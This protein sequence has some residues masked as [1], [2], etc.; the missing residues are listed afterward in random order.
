M[1][2]AS[3]FPRSFTSALVGNVEHPSRLWLCKNAHSANM[4]CHCGNST[5][6][7]GCPALTRLPFSS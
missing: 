6:V 1:T 3:P 5:H 7:Y 4:K 2:L